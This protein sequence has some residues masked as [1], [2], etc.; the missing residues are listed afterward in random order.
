[1]EFKQL[2]SQRIRRGQNK[3]QME[4]KS[5]HRLIMDYIVTSPWPFSFCVCVAIG[6]YL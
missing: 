1:M 4:P 3:M 6:H 2:H 5:S